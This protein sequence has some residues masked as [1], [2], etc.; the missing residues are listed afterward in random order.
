[1]IKSWNSHAISIVWLKPIKT[2]FKLLKFPCPLVWWSYSLYRCLPIGNTHFNS[3][4][5]LLWG[6]PPT[7]HCHNNL[8]SWVCHTG[9]LCSEMISFT[10]HSGY[11]FPWVGAALIFPQNCIF[12]EIFPWIQHNLTMFPFTKKQRINNYKMFE[13]MNYFP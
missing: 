10:T 13:I 6:L 8:L 11:P 7:W 9:K 5:S 1:M 2:G 4:F 3:H 12:H